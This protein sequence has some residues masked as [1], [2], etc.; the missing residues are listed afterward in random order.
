MGLLVD[1]PK[2]GFGTTSDGNTSRRFFADPETSFYIT[3]INLDLIKRLR[4]M[5]EAL[6]LMVADVPP[7]LSSFTSTEDNISCEDIDEDDEDEEFN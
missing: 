7:S 5:L 3:G 6:D 1:V 4:V 2:A